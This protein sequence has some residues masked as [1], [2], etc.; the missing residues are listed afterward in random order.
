MSK[1]MEVGDGMVTVENPFSL[2]SKALHPGW[3][4]VFTRFCVN[5]GIPRA[6]REEPAEHAVQRGARGEQR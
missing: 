6:R 2:A 3:S 4:N 5:C 1:V